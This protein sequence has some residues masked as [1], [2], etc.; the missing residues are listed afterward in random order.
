MQPRPLTPSRLPRLGGER[1]RPFLRRE[2][3]AQVDL[4]EVAPGNRRRCGG[5]LRLD[6]GLHSW[7]GGRLEGLWRDL[8]RRGAGHKRHAE[9]GRGERP[10]GTSGTSGVAQPWRPVPTAW[11]YYA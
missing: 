5:C 4:L 6:I 1:P 9:E 3:I 2:E 7:H 10:E 11:T 8:G